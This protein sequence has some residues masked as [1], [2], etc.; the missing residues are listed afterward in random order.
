MEKS[1]ESWQRQKVPPAQQKNGRKERSDQTR[2]RGRVKQRKGCQGEMQCAYRK[3]HSLGEAQEKDYIEK[4]ENRLCKEQEIRTLKEEHR[5]TRENRGQKKTSIQQI[6]IEEKKRIGHVLF[7]ENR[8]IWPKI[9]GRER[10]E[11]RRQQKYY[12]SWQKKMENSEL[13]ISLQ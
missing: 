5:V 13:L 8:A 11:K 9:I 12:K 3:M 4:E 6:S 10:K 1:G 7:V 2:T